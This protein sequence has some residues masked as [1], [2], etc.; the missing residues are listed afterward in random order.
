M[1]KIQ[2]VV[3]RIGGIIAWVGVWNLLDMAAQENLYINIAYSVIGFI[4]WYFSGEFEEPVRYV[5]ITDRP[6]V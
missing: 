5:E 3:N 4:I 2:Q 1:T 6:E